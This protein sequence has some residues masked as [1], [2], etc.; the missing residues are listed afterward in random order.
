MAQVFG[1]PMPAAPSA[2]AH[3]PPVCY[4]VVIEA[5]GSMVAGLYLANRERVN[6]LDAASSE[7]ANTTAGLMPTQGACGPEWDDALQGHSAQERAEARV[8]T[9]AS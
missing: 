6:A 5:G 1:M 2:T 7:L 3:R 4:V 9:L 8:Y